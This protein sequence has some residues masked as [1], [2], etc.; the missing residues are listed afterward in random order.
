MK[1]KHM[2]L[3]LG[4]RHVERT[5]D[6]LKTRYV[7]PYRQPVPVKDIKTQLKELRGE[8]EAQKGLYH[9]QLFE[10]L[11]LELGSS[12]KTLLS[13][14]TTLKDRHKLLSSRYQLWCDYVA[15]R[16]RELPE[17]M[18]FTDQMKSNLN[19]SYEAYRDRK[20]GVL[21]PSKVNEMHMDYA[22]LF[23]F[24][25][26]IDVLFIEQMIHPSRGY[27]LHLSSG[28]SFDELLR[29]YKTLIVATYE[30]LSGQ[31]L[32]AHHLS[33]LGFWQLV[34]KSSRG[35]LAFSDFQAALR[36]V[37]YNNVKSKEDFARL[38]PSQVST[39]PQDHFNMT[40]F[41]IGFETFGDLYVERNL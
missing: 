28:V 14:T 3:N 21:L 29:L 11:A 33:G 1:L 34:D 10:D 31:S 6:S 40:E 4:A 8:T 9:T 41:G 35:H 7:N 37:R 32:L 38:F 23:K 16:E 36:M 15:A 20:E 18:V 39:L 13:G 26:I 12:R 5:V 22:S 30:R 25:P 2:Q 24:N 19:Y 27:L 17:E